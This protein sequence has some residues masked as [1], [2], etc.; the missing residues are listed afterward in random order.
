M[1]RMI[2]QSL[3]TTNGVDLK[4]PKMFE[5]PPRVT[6]GEP[7]EKITVACVW[8]GTAYPV[9]YVINL[10]NMVARHLTIP[11]EFVC[12]SDRDDVPEGVRK[13][14]TPVPNE[15][16]QGK[17]QGGHSKGWWAKVGLYKPD[18]FGDA[19]RV[20]YMD[21]DIVITGSL[22]KIVSVQE[23]FCMIENFGPNKGH[24]AHNSSVVVWTPNE[25]SNEI[26]T[27]FSP[28]VV[29]ELHGDQ[30]W[31]WRVMRDDIHDYPKSWVV[32]YKYEKHPQW[33]HA[34]KDTAITIFHGKPKPHEVRDPY[35]VNNWK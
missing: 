27:K 6:V 2:T 12:I 19:K 1:S 9:K 3:I 4:T 8:W 13:I 17:D 7:P 25:K 14:P 35:I 22:D 5:P 32:S 33:H 28:Q 26:Y 16:C 31:Q 10:R 34:N 11:Y 15:L 24:A 29:R 21:L 23:P 30:C 18:L 20:L